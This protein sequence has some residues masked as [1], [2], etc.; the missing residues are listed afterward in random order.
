MSK[1][2]LNQELPL[3][4]DLIKDLN[5]D[6][7]KPQK[8]PPLHYRPKIYQLPLPNLK[9]PSTNLRL[10]NLTPLKSLPESPLKNTS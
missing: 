8:L 3:I 2:I 9:L 7:K 5:Q 4:K 6:L 1:N 10:P